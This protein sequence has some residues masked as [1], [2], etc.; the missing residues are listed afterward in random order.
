[1]KSSSIALFWIA[2]LCV[3]H[4]ASSLNLESEWKVYMV[5]ILHKSYLLMFDLRRALNCFTGQGKYRKRYSSSLEEARRKSNYIRALEKVEKHNKMNLSW[6][7]GVNQ[8]S[9]MVRCH[10]LKCQ[11]YN[12]TCTIL[13]GRREALHSWI[14]FAR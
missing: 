12:V 1:M 13:V 10:N 3:L 4:A 14:S 9:D 11:H 8:F 5:I 7:M 6:A 2:A